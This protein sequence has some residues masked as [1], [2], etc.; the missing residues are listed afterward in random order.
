MDIVYIRNVVG[1]EPNVHWFGV[2][3]TPCGVDADGSSEI[4]IER[5]KRWI[6]VNNRF[7]RSAGILRDDFTDHGSLPNWSLH[8]HQ[9]C[10]DMR[11]YEATHQG[12]GA[13]QERISPNLVDDDRLPIAMR[14]TM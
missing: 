12:W 8:T 10:K 7:E 6:V 5:E 3:E 13:G 9:L 4:V 11:E 2:F 1:C 14:A